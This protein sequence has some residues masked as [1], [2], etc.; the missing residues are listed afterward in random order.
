M[1][2]DVRRLSSPALLNK[3]SSDTKVQSAAAICDASENVYHAYTCR[4]IGEI[5]FCK[6]AVGISSFKS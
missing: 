1:S 6:R 2:Q 4:N 3:D 5:V